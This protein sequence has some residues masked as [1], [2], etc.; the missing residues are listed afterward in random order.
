M[1]FYAVVDVEA[2]VFRNKKGYMVNIVCQAA[3]IVVNWYGKECIGEKY[4]VCQPQTDIEIAQ[5]FDADITEVRRAVSAYE[6]ITGD[7]Y[8]HPKDDPKY[9]KWSRVRHRI[10]SVCNILTYAVFA[11][12]ISL[13][14]AVFYGEIVFNDLAHWGCPKYPLS[15]HDPL[16]ECRFFAQYIPGLKLHNKQQQQQQRC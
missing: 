14:N 13:E 1:L 7:K 9:F 15:T 4:Y 5:I 6:R 12:G 8:L 2:L 10:Q 16:K 3:F 11:K